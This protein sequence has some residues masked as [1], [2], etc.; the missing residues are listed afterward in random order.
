MLK[1]R[2][3]DAPQKQFAIWSNKFAGIGKVYSFGIGYKVLIITLS[4]K[5]VN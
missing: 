1:I 3:A 2:I 4:S 5:G